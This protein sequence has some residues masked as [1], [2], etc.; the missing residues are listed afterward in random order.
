MENPVYVL[1]PLLN[2]SSWALTCTFTIICSSVHVYVYMHASI[3]RIS[4]AW[5]MDNLFYL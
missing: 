2:A 3:I 5:L 4:I 1:L